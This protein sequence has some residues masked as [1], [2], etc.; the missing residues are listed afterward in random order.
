MPILYEIHPSPRRSVMK[1]L[2][3][4]L[5][6]GFGFSLLGAGSVSGPPDR[7]AAAEAFLE[8]LERNEREESVHAFDH[9][10]RVGWSFFPAKRV[11]LR[12]GDL[13][14]E[15]RAA[16]DA[17]LAVALGERGFQKVRDVLLVEPVTDRGGGV[18]T[19]PGEYVM[20]F[21]G[22]ISEDGLWAWR[23][24]GHHVALNQM[25]QG[26][27]V[28][29]AT[30]SFLGSAPMRSADGLE[31]LRREIAIATNIARGLPEAQKK[32]AVKPAA[33]GEV[34]SGMRVDWKAPNR[35]GISGDNLSSEDRKQ[36]RA[37][38]YEHV[39]THAHDVVETFFEEFDKTPSEDVFFVY[40]GSLEQDGPH[41]YRLQGPKW[42]MEYVNVQGNA[43]HVHTV[44]RMSDGEF[45][46][47]ASRSKE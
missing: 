37:L 12:I 41:G 2:P 23:L 18:H 40:F 44:W 15:E 8:T 11:G 47:I 39:A 14:D 36:L 20:L 42:V 3:M 16:L 29:A 10:D 35:E 17:F 7:I 46:P 22:D 32:R 21:Y 25:L 34:V 9:P 43:N 45:H 26:D 31:P 33:P 13:D 1:S 5:V 38:A 28:I 27:K 24:E 30:P 19:G 4:L 6:V